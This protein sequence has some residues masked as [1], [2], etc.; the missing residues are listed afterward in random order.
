MIEQNPFLWTIQAANR[1]HH[2]TRRASRLIDL[3]GS[4]V[5]GDCL[6]R[7]DASPADKRSILFPPA[8]V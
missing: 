2:C 3:D 8:F 4:P 5:C 1:C 7:L 6:R